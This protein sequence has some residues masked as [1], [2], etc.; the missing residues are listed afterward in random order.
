MT[1]AR[2]ILVTVCAVETAGVMTATTV[3][4]WLAVVLS[5]FAGVGATVTV[6]AFAILLWEV[7]HREARR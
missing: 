7:F 2:M 5:I 1:V 4:L 3:P 6:E